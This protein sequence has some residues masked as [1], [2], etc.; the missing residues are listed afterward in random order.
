M[1]HVTT[2]VIDSSIITTLNATT[3]RITTCDI[4]SSIVLQRTP[5]AITISTSLFCDIGQVL[6]YF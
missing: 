4:T 5:T 6:F 3:G 2:S 1:L